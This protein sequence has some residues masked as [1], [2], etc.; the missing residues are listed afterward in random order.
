MPG[1]ALAAMGVVFGD[2]GTSP[3]YALQTVFSIDH[4]A[5][6]PS[7]L[8][9]FGIISLVF[10]SILAI[11]SVKYVLLVMRA[12]NDGEGGILALVALLR[13]K[14]RGRTRLLSTVTIMGVVG[15][16]LFYGDS[17]ITPAI[18]V[19][20]A[21]EGLDLVTPDAHSYVLPASVLILT[22]LF[23]AQRF[24][25]E[26]VGRAFGPVM[27]L[28]FGALAALGVPQIVAN[29]EIL[30]A[31]SPHHALEF[32]IS[33]PGI[34]F[35]AMGAVVLCI[36]G[37]EALY[38]DM[39][40]FGPR[41]IRLSWFAVVLPCLMLNYFGQGAMIL[42][43]PSTVASPF[44][45]LAPGWARVPLVIL[46]TAATIIASQAVISGAFS[47]SQQAARLR[48]L[49]RLNVR[50]T[51]KAEGGQIYIG[52]INWL[53]YVGVV[54]LIATFQSSERLATAYGIAVTG[55]LMLTTTLFLFLAHHV[56]RWRPGGSCWWPPPSACWNWSTSGP[57][58]SRSS[59]AV[60][61]RWSSR[62]PSSSS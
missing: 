45:H 10:W 34:A 1:L 26:K 19:M 58:W 50:H 60:G 52:S 29:P 30:L 59:L 32:A 42:A 24:G 22:M 40:H 49:P 20:S 46:A 23:V 8:D 31:M 2:I 4:N 57:T 61:F 53:L 14:L 54:V 48:L 25:T 62:P 28:W 6:E 39:G 47:V 55:T 13:H 41:P 7:R 33:R 11:V 16:A 27:V 44:F 43:D 35:I 38:A 36:T 12:D 3:L 51:S 56:W 5:V 17:V 37:A 9:V 21:I 15:A 18:S